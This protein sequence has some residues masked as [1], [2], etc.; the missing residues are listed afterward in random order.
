MVR[1]AIASLACSFVVG[2]AIAAAKPTPHAPSIPE[3]LAALEASKV[4]FDDALSKCLDQ[5][6]NGLPYRIELSTHERKPVYLVTM[7]VG[8]PDHFITLSAT[9]GSIVEQRDGNFNRYGTVLRIRLAEPN[10]G[11]VQAMQLAE[12]EFVG[13][14]AY[15]SEATVKGSTI[16]F[17]VRLA[18]KD[19]IKH[20][21]LTPE[22]DFISAGPPPTS[23]K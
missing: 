10:I 12:A 21:V 2:A 19:E 22:G 20:V 23:A 17:T 1:L 13:F 18:S 5:V 14:R 16:Q 7:L 4:T 9:D 15:F 6:V 3:R 8:D 11:L